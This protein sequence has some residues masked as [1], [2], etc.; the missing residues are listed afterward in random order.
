MDTDQ[1]GARTSHHGGQPELLHGVP[2]EALVEAVQT[3]RHHPAIV[4]AYDRPMGREAR[5]RILRTRL[6]EVATRHDVPV[7][8]IVE[9]LKK[10]LPRD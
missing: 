3:V 7:S 2:P 8:D 4:H 5:I 6:Q 10:V 9:A 1:A